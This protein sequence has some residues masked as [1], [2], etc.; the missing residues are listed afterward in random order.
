MNKN[1][2]DKKDGW[3][4]SGGEEER[5]GNSRPTHPDLMGPFPQ[6]DTA[7]GAVLGRKE[8]DNSKDKKERKESE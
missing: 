5:R 8:N 4:P 3:I 1:R 6:S 7:Q 2:K